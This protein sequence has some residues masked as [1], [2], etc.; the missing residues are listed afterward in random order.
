MRHRT[1]SLRAVLLDMGGV[2][3][4]PGNAQGLPAGKLDYRGREALVQLLKRSGASSTL[5]QLDGLLFAPWHAE[6]RRR[7]ETG[8]EADWKPHLTRLRRRLH[9]H[10][11]DLQLLGTWFAPYGE[12]MTLLPDAGETVAALAAAGYALG[13][14]SN[15]PLPGKLYL[16]LLARHGLVAPFATLQFSYDTGSRKPSPAMIRAALAAL[17]VEPEHAAMVG[18]RRGADVAA[19]RAAGVTTI[20]LESADGGGPTPDYAIRRLGELPA[21]LARL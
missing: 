8:R 7:Y 15:V 20:W 9:V 6:Y 1:R 11:H 21:L 5:E 3:L 16:R 13:L 4:D 14:V 12:T 19:G 18:D 17:A 10:A 2:L